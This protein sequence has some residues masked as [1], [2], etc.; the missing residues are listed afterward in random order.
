[1]ELF[2]NSAGFY[3][4]FFLN[5]VILLAFFIVATFYNYNSICHNN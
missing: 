4:L 1:M 5:K 3:I 2:I